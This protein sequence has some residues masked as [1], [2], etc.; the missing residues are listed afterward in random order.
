M[1]V[2]IPYSVPIFGYICD[3]FGPHK[4]SLLAGSFFGLGY[5]LASLAYSHELPYQVMVFAFTLIGMGTSSM[6]FAGIT[7][8]AKNFTGSRGLA[9]SLPIA[10]FGLSGLW[11]SQFVSRAFVGENGMLMISAVFGTFSVFLPGVGI[12]GGLCLQVF[13][14]EGEEAQGESERLLAEDGGERGFGWVDNAEDGKR[15]INTATRDFLKDKTMWWFAVGVF[16]VTGPGEAFI[17]NMG[18]L[19]QSLYPP[20]TSSAHID[21]ATHV[22]I[23]A[24]TSTLA[25][26]V[27]GILSDYLGPSIN[28]PPAQLSRSFHPRFSRIILLIAVSCLLLTAHLLLTFA[29]ISSLTSYFWLVSAL[30]GSGYGAIFTLAPTVVSVVWG[31]ENFGTNWGIVMSTPAVGATVYGLLYASVYDD[32]AGPDGRCWG[33][34]CYRGAFG[35]MAVGAMFAVGGWLWAWRGK[36]GWKERGVIV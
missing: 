33:G 27:V 10:S 7:T 28:P 18:S 20:G 6:Y 32:H 1:I 25:R 14:A 30:V 2:L 35:V 13:P 11:M 9:L 23:I 8:C 34:E 16:L 12:V 4:L 3:N 21:P 31:T 17:N 26:I 24:T 19:I 22:S 29:S 5:L 36:G 15:W